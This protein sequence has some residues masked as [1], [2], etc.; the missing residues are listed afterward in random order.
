MEKQFNIFKFYFY[1]FKLRIYLNFIIIDA[2]IEILFM[3][4]FRPGSVDPERLVSL[5]RLSKNY[6]QNRLS[7][8]NHS[9]N[10]FLNKNK[11][12]FL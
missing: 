9:R 3:K 8:E 2:L 4:N 5:G 11:S 1:F 12:K 10:V 6:L 7:A